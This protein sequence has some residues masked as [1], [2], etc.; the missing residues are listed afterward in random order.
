MGANTSLHNICL[1]MIKII[2][3]NCHTVRQEQW[4]FITAR[5]INVLA[6]R[7]NSLAD[8][9]LHVSAR[10]LVEK[11]R[12]KNS[13]WIDNVVISA[14]PPFLFRVSSSLST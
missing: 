3:F 8:A 4:F 10:V 13:L 7:Q 1:D 12:K 9:P 2:D 5:Y 11:T 14:V 6:F